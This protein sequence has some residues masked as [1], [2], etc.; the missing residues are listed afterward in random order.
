PGGSPAGRSSLVGR[1]VLLAAA[2]SLAVLVLAGIALSVFFDQAE[3]TRFDTELAKTVEGLLA[4]TT[5]E[6]GVIK[7]PAVTSQRSQ[8]AFSGSYWQIVNVGPPA[9]RQLITSRS[10]WDRTLPIPPSVAADLARAP[11]ETVSF[12]VRG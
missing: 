10:L 8:R 9:S 5:V 1:L 2:W 3:L 7:P 4:G 12:E 6:H 11:G